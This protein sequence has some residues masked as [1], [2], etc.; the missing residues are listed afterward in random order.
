MDRKLIAKLFVLFIATTLVMTACAGNQEQE[1]LATLNA[2]QTQNAQKETQAA[3]NVTQTA[4][5]AVVQTANAPA[6]TIVPSDTP[7]PTPTS[8]PTATEAPSPTV[9][10]TPTESASPTAPP[11]PVS[12]GAVCLT[13]KTESGLNGVRV[14]N[15]SGQ[16]FS[17]TLRCSGGPCQDKSNT[18]YKCKFPPGT[19]MFYVWPGRYNIS[20]T[21][22]GESQSFVHPLNAQWYIQLKK[23]K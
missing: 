18:Y 7:E 14:G 9:S 1:L 8:E 2:I 19:Y 13:E 11:A 20:W 3:L 15:N 4:V 12:S 16:D 17:I 23:C 22:C 6:P 21:I 5:E 10:L